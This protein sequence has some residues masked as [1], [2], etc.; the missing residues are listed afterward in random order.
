MEGILSPTKQAKSCR[1]TYRLSNQA[2][3]QGEQGQSNERKE[4]GEEKEKKKTKKEGEN[5]AFFRRT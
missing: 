3:E 5:K 4:E 1:E 2:G